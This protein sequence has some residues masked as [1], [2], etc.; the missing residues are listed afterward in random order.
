[1]KTALPVQTQV[2]A[3][4]LTFQNFAGRLPYAQQEHLQK[5]CQ[6]A[7]LLHPTAS[8]I[9]ELLDATTG[10]PH[11]IASRMGIPNPS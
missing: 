5:T 3:F 1:M 8:G 11:A 6:I 10:V 7:G 4:Y 9:E 2:G